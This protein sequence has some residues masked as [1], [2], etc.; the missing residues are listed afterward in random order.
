MPEPRLAFTLPLPPK[1][2]SPN[3]R[4]RHWA[5]VSTAKAAYRRD[6]GWTAKGAMF[7][8]AARAAET[9]PPPPMV[10]FPLAAPVTA[11]VTFVVPD[12]R[13]R[14]LDNLSASMKAA[15]DGIVDAGVLVD[16]SSEHLKHAAPELVVERGTREV[17]VVL[18]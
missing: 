3:Y 7:A 9:T 15:W 8:A 10:N 13:R 1:E 14:D 11:H 17:R 5:Q 2:L 6:C 4:A 18:A 12:K 16:D